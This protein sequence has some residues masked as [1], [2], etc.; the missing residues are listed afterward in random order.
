MR[1][2]RTHLEARAAERPA[3]YL[4]V[5]AAAGWWDG[6]D[7]VITDEA[8]HALVERYAEPVKRPG[9]L[10]MTRNF[11]SAVVAWASAGFPVVSAVQFHGRAGICRE[12]EHYL[13]VPVARCA[14]CGCSA[15]LKPWLATEKCPKGKW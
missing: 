1:I 12:C 5:C 7:L 13:A 11:A 15:S 4:D 3:D 9:M 8:W 2:P 10:E 14:V 6:D